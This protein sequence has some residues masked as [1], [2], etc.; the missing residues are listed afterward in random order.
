MLLS[1]VSHSEEIVDLKMLLKENNMSIIQLSKHLKLSREQ[2][3]AILN[4]PIEDISLG[5]LEAILA[6]IGYSMNII[7]KKNKSQL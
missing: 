3:G 7:V 1:K 2:T 4:K 6:L 5:R